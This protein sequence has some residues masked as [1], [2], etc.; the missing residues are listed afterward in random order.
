MATLAETM[1]IDE[2]LK[3]SKYH[4]QKNDPPELDWSDPGA[5]GGLLG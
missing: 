5:V 4:S 3:W 2:M 1:T